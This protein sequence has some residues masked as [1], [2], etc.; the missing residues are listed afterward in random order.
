MESITNIIYNNKFKNFIKE[1]RNN[2][3]ETEILNNR[4]LLAK[5]HDDILEILSKIR[6]YIISNYRGNIDLVDMSKPIHKRKHNDI[7]AIMICVVG[8]IDECITFN[9]VLN[10]IKGTAIDFIFTTETCKC[11]CGHLTSPEHSFVLENKI[12]KKLL[13]VG[14][15]CVDKYD[16]LTKGQK[17][18][19]KEDIQKK[20]KQIEENKQCIDCEKYIIPKNEPTRIIR[21]LPC[22]RVRNIPKEKIGICG[23]CENV[24]DNTYPTCVDCVGKRVKKCLV[25]NY[26]E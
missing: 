11:S 13:V 17:K 26:V 14:N 8:E 12:T 9:D 21:C 15:V 7:F 10:Q 6:K 18:K 5:H 20:K 23:I 24:Y 22:Y 3:P 16:L 4:R 2:I 25:I 1:L 19:I